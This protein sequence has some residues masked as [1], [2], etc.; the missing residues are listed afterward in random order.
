MRFFILGSEAFLFA[1]MDYSTRFILSSMTSPVKLGVKPLSMFREAA[2]IVPWVFVT[3]GLDEFV[4]PAKKAFWRRKGRRFIHVAE[5]HANNEF[6][7]NNVQ[8]SLNGELKPLL[9][10]RGGFKLDNSPLV[11]LAIL[12]YNF[13][14]HHTSL[15][16]KTPAEVAGIC[17][18]GDLDIT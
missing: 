2:S 18:E 4:K 13:F 10:K 14:R 1:V 15:D 16:G 9:T 11:D 5:I 8:E 6:N 7:H 3:D 17:I 12:G